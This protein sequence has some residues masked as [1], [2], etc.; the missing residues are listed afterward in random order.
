M[1]A[2]ENSLFPD[3]QI[4]RKQVDKSVLQLLTI[5]LQFQA[6]EKKGKL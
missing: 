3:E 2:I 5:V 4:N 1:F 6:N